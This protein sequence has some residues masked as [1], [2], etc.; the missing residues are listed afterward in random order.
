[1]G[2]LWQAIHHEPRSCR[3][4]PERLAV[5]G[6]GGPRHMVVSREGCKGLHD[7]PAV[8]HQGRRSR[9]WWG[10]ERA[11]AL[12][13]VA[14]SQ[15]A[16]PVTEPTGMWEVTRYWKVRFT[17]AHS[18]AAIIVDVYRDCRN[19]KAAGRVEEPRNIYRTLH[20]LKVAGVKLTGTECWNSNVA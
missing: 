19:V 2:L 1:M 10:I 14:P 6:G 5:V 18:A 16:L 15:A 12:D 7:S 11:A 17:C 8:Q 13:R 9:C 3:A 20:N 4:I